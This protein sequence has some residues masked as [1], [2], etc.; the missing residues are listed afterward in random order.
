MKVEFLASNGEYAEPEYTA[1]Y[2][3]KELIMG[4]WIPT[5]ED[6]DDIPTVNLIYPGLEVI[7][8]KRDKELENFLLDKFK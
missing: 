1:L 3:D 2:I 4:F 6:S 8:V 5:D 7:T